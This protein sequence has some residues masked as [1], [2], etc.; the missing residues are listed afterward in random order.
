MYFASPA[1]KEEKPELKWFA[2]SESL[3]FKL[4]G[5]G[6]RAWPVPEFQPGVIQI[7]PV[8]GS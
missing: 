1:I 4:W 7:Q 5:V 8:P 6:I 3:C 2:A